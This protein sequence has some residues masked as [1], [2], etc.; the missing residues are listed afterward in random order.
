[1]NARLLSERFLCPAARSSQLSDAKTE[2]FCVHTNK[3]QG[4][5]RGNP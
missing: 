5:L 3:I 4:L 2:L 1:V